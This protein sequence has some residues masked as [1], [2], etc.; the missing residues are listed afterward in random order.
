MPRR[1]TRELILETSLALF[2]QHG[3]GNVTTNLIADEAEI[4]PGNLY[5]HF[6]H[7]QDIVLALFYRFAESLAPLVEVS[8]E[9]G[10]DAESLWFR[11]HVIFEVK[12][13]YR[14]IY[15]NIADISERM[16]DVG[17]ALRG[18]LMREK[19]AVSA[20]LAGLVAN[21]A[22]LADDKQQTMLIDQITLTLTYW[23]PFAD[24]FDPEGARDGSAQVGAIARVFLLALPYLRQPW[25][26]EAERLAEAYLE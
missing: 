22:M 24:E 23:I 6:R 2:N 21:G 11:L 25:R 17:I 20:L 7:K 12:G 4:S 26:G 5:Y 14:F 1:D 10:I 15:R 18:M 8:T 3:E 19:N 16:P 13:R 9:S